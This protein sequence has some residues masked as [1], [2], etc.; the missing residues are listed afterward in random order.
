MLDFSSLQY[1]RRW[2]VLDR[3]SSWFDLNYPSYVQYSVLTGPLCLEI[4][5]KQTES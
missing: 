1:E 3:E 5:K 2:L 4:S